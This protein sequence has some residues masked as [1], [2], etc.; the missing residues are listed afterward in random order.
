MPDT[1]D[2]SRLA[3]SSICFLWLMTS[4]L[5]TSS[6]SLFDDVSEPSSG[7]L[8]DKYFHIPERRHKFN[9]QIENIQALQLR[10]TY[11]QHISLS[12]S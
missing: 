6:S 9:L 8:S 1:A 7:I 3:V 4:A 5:A 2:R 12:S 11:S 10:R